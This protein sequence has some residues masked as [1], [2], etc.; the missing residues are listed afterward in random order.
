MYKITNAEH[1]ACTSERIYVGSDSQRNI[2]LDKYR[3]FNLQF[4]I[5]R[6]GASTLAVP[7]PVM[8]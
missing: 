3:R 2:L 5:G 8:H 1:A 6:K 4:R 7:L